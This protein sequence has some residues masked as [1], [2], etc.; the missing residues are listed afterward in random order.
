M[1]SLK[2]FGS[3]EQLRTE[4]EI[5]YPKTEVVFLKTTDHKT[6]HGYW[7]PYN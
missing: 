6:I 3:F 1:W 5:R 7:I 2:I 4:M